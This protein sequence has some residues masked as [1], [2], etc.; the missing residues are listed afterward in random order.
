MNLMLMYGVIYSSLK[1]FESECE[2]QPFRLSIACA[3]CRTTYPF[4]SSLRWILFASL[5]AF[6]KLPARTRVVVVVNVYPTMS[7]CFVPGLI[8][9]RPFSSGGSSSPI[10][11]ISQAFL[12]STPSCSR[13]YCMICF[14]A[15]FRS[16]F[17]V[18]ISRRSSTYRR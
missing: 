11:Q 5:R 17:D 8:F 13:Q 18:P 2:T 10:W 16:D 1:C 14:T 15:F 3:F 7:T 4:S 9:I 12:I 6:R